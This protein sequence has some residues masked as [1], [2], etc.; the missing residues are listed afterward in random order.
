MKRNYTSANEI[1]LQTIANLIGRDKGT[2]TTM[3]VE[4]AGPIATSSTLVV[5]TTYAM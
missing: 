5:T 4:A 3:M 1:N 2:A